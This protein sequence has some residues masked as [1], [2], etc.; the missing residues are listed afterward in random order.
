[1]S[2][3]CSCGS[4]FLKKNRMQHINTNKHQTWL[5]DERWAARLNQGSQIEPVPPTEL[6]IAL[7][8]E[9]APLGDEFPDFDLENKEPV[10]LPPPKG[11]AGGTVV[12][13]IDCYKC[14]EFKLA[15]QIVGI[16]FGVTSFALVLWLISR[17]GTP[18]H[19]V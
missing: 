15:L 2:V 17:G 11:T 1:M 8:N 12:P 4:T 5:R 10:E 6:F 16:S 7:E 9:G 3:N 13:S 18:R 19:P 14:R